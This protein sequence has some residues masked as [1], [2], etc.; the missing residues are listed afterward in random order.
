MTLPPQSDIDRF[1]IAREDR[2]NFDT[3][4]QEAANLILPTRDFLSD[5]IVPGLRL[6]QQ[7]FNDTAPLANDQTAAALHGLLSNPQN[8]WMELTLLDFD[9]AND[10]EAQ[11]WLYD[12]TNRLL[13]FFASTESG[14]ATN[15]HEVYEDILAFG[16]AVMHM[17]ETRNSFRFVA[18]QL[19]N[20]FVIV[21]E[22][23]D[24][25]DLF[26]MFQM[27]NREF[28]YR[29]DGTNP[30]PS[31][32][33]RTMA[34]DV[35]SAEN[36]ITILHAIIRR[37]PRDP[38]SPT[39]TNMP[40]A[41]R[42]HELQ[43]RHK[44]SE[45]GFREQPYLLPRWTKAPEEPYGRGPGMLVLASIMSVNQISKDVLIATEQKVRPPINVF[46]NSQAGPISTQPG[47]INWIRSGTR[48]LPSPMD[49]GVFP[50]AA[51]KQI[52]TD[53]LTIEKAYFLDILNLPER[54]RM[55]AEEIITRRQ[56]GL[57]RAS[58]IIARVTAELLS[59]AIRRAFNWHL[60]TGRLLPVPASLQG[61]RLRVDYTSPMAQSQKAAGSQN[62]TQALITAAPLINANPSILLNVDDDKT[63]RD[64]WISQGADPRLLRNPALV[65]RLR[66]QLEQQQQAAALGATAKDFAGA[67]RDAAIAAKELPGVLP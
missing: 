28:V 58:P 17:K 15:V 39:F 20:M 62:I 67:G 10:P 49:L 36:K 5:N 51:Q 33:T 40:W 18:K 57:I 63:F 26:R 2:R 54:N 37:F 64:T 7:I 16:T 6:R 31:D 13:A 47:S 23:G 48:E 42:Y 8:R 25:T 14:W 41:S 55:T 45:G 65:R 12:A 24:V 46:A 53:K 44:V 30:G 61:R 38:L 32:T 66:Q 56:Q 50:E 29:F 1:E 59:P 4:W 11:A 43:T 60:R 22:D 21:N 35:K 3:H 27:S 52:E 19:A 9:D 34:E